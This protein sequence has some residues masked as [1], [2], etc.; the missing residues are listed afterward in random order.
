MSDISTGVNSYYV[1]QLVEK[2]KDTTQYVVVCYA[3]CVRVVVCALCCVVRCV[4]VG[5]LYVGW[6]RAEVG[7]RSIAF[8]Y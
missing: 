5:R 2:D 1:L 3:L 8:Y 7:L 4:E 6:D